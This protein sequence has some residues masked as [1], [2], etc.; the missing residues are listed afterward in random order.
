MSTCRA[1]SPN[2]GSQYQIEICFLE[3]GGAAGTGLSTGPQVE[4][5]EAFWRYPRCFSLDFSARGASSLPVLSYHL[6]GRGLARNATHFP[7]PSHRTEHL[8]FN[9]L[10]REPAAVLGGHLFQFWETVYRNID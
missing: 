2:L 5:R 9:P 1:A 6:D 10:P 3:Q 8:G 4:T 7:H